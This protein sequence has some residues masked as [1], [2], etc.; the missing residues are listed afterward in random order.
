MVIPLKHVAISTQDP[1]ASRDFFANV[2]GWTVAGR[3]DS[4][5]AQGYYVTDGT[6]NIALLR[7]KNRPAA[8]LEFPEGYNGLHHLGFQCE[9]VEATAEYMEDQGFPPRHDINIAQGLGKNPDKDNAEYKMTGTAS[10]M[11]DISERGWVG[12]SSYKPKAG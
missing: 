11:I 8:G 9:D 10:V 6:I 12:T 5:N 2:M 3:V 7:F 4:R 1:E